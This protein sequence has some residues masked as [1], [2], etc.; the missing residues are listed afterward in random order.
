MRE[1]LVFT[2][3]DEPKLD[4]SEFENTEE[5]LGN[6]LKTEMNIEKPI[7]FDRVH[8]IGVSQEQRSYPRPIVAKFQNFKD[9][10]YVR[11][12]APK[13]LKG[14][15]FGVREQ[16]PKVI[17]DRRK[18]LYPE[19]KKAR[20]DPNNRVRLVRD[21][22]NINN[23]QFILESEDEQSDYE[24]DKRVKPG[25]K[26]SQNKYAYSES[27]KR[28]YTINRKQPY[29]REQQP[30]KRSGNYAKGRYMYQSSKSR[31]Q[32]I[33]TMQTP[34]TFKVKKFNTKC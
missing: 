26:Y 7:P 15:P 16:F 13:T 29:N 2:G 33:G 5:I 1:N 8:R 11:S 25:Q 19:M 6:F 34:Q 27:H 18:K 10:E 22:L 24:T 23:R 21:K 30:N 17:E 14:K 12:S 32:Q 20:R 9:R 31:V 3:I 4:K 28:P